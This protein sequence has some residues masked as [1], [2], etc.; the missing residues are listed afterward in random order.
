MNIVF[1][2]FVFT[3]IFLTSQTDDFNVPCQSNHDCKNEYFCGKNI[4]FY[5]SALLLESP[6]FIV[7]VF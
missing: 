4:H 7:V 2:V 5:N 3:V 6:Y 1:L